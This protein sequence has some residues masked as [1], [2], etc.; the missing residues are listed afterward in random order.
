MH[1]FEKLEVWKR[2]CRLAVEIYNSLQSCKDYGLKDQMTRAAVSIP[3]NIA[4]GYERRT[5]KEYAQFLSIAKG[6]AGELRTQIYIAVK[7]GVLDPK[8]ASG[9]T[10]ELKEL[11]SMLQSIISKL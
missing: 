11:A 2:G 1:S 9:M 3:S 8:T 7:I 4:E 5:G 6:S 10:R